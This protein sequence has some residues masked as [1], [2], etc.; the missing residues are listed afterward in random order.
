MNDVTAPGL[1]AI[2]RSFLA[3]RPGALQLFRK[4]KAVLRELGKRWVKDSGLRPQLRSPPAPG[5]PA[6]D[7]SNGTGTR[8]VPAPA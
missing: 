3:A 1:E 6:R 8:A 4:R 7:P 2:F 5:A